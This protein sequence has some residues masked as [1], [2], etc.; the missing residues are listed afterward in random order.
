MLISCDWQS[1]GADPCYN[2]ITIAHPSPSVMMSGSGSGSL[3]VEVSPPNNTLSVSTTL[4]MH[5]P[6]SSQ[7]KEHQY[8]LKE[9]HVLANVCRGANTSEYTCYWNQY[10]QFTGKLCAECHP[11][12]RSVEKTLNFVQFSIGISLVMTGL[13]VLPTMAFLTASD[14]TPKR[15]QVSIIS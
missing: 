5:E 14:Y 7:I 1:I 3:E 6:R 9:I 8:T 4:S 13:A 11:A 2:H 12:C 10:S 15:L